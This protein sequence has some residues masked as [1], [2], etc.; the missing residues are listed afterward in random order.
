MLR[1]YRIWD[2]PSG[3]KV[4]KYQDPRLLKKILKEAKY[5]IIPSDIPDENLKDIR[6]MY[7]KLQLNKIYRADLCYLCRKNYSNYIFLTK[8]KRIP[9]NEK[10]NQYL[11]DSCAWN[12]LLKRVEM[13]GVKLTPG[14][15]EILSS[16]FKKLRDI[17]RIE[18]NFD[19]A[20]NPVEDND[21]SLFDVCDLVTE[22]HETM[23]VNDLS[24]SSKFKTILIQNGIKNLLPVQVKA[25]KNGLLEGKN[26][27]IASSTS[28]GKTLVGELAGIHNLVE[29]KS[30][31]F[32][33]VVPLVALANQKYLEFKK[34]YGKLGLSVAIRV[35]KSRIDKPAKNKS[36]SFDRK[37]S[38]SDIIVGTYE[39]VDYL[40]RSGKKKSIPKLGTIVIDEIQMYKD[41][42]RGPRLDGFIAR[43]KYLYPDAQFIYLS[44]TIAN[45]KKLSKMMGAKLV[46][47]LERPVPL[48]RHLIPCLN[49]S[50]KLR[51][52]TTL[53]RRE[54]RKTSSYGYRGQSIIF[55]HSRRM[56]H[57]IA[58]FLKLE[59]IRAEPYHSG[60]T[61]DQ[62]LR[63]EKKFERQEIAA[64]VTTAAL[65]AGV[66]LPAS[67]VIF[68]SLTMGI[69]WLTVAEF[70][71]MLGRAGRFH[72]HDIGKVYLLVEPG[73]SYHSSQTMEEDK[74]AMK[75]LT[76]KMQETQPFF[77]MDKV[78]SEVLAFISM[79]VFT[80]LDE[81]KTFHE[82]LFGGSASIIKMLN[83]LHSRQLISVKEKGKKISILPMGKA[84]C[85]SFLDIDEG[86]ELCK[87]VETYEISIIEMASSIKPLKNVYV[88]NA[89]I[90][91]LAKFQR[92]RGHMSSNF[93]G[94][95]ILDFMNLD[96][97]V[98][99]PNALK[100]KKLSRFALDILSRWALDIFN[101]TCSDR[102]YCDC[103]VKNLAKIILRL[104]RRA[105]MDPK[106][107]SIYLKEKYEIMMYPGDIYDF[108]D[109]ILHGLDAIERFAEI[110]NKK[111]MLEVIKKYREK[112]ENP[113]E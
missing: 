61:Y 14:L 108:L 94:G 76:G 21:F 93:F 90:S 50:E 75:L 71:Q 11:C 33:F 3:K 109:N 83:Y 77:S 48:E 2:P 99:S 47:F 44:A 86:M 35:G 12:V 72:K 111:K 62:R 96:S 105:K 25:I 68:H 113:G 27:L 40:L 64:V 65:G 29:K 58:N 110:L 73:K 91:E 45:P 30:G 32:M 63:V 112:I 24:T 38:T 59:R 60:L 87:N 31:A 88:T 55:V 95:R 16:K 41:E 19:P 57:E 81:I 43:L 82:N 107:I 51:L 85:E 74:V 26:L 49:D 17:E 46:Q 4:K 53:V 15:M 28:S 23:E 34:K 13:R 80:N 54:Y 42:E 79:Q 100:R 10:E 84:I 98:V 52:I 36:S 7:K 1:P 66:D 101:C 69:E 97:N 22:D 20:W 9:L 5:T 67:Q 106:K 89:I 70:N 103:G 37:T 39:G 78:A 92:G 104:R 56:V 102:P 18:K 8:S 6:E